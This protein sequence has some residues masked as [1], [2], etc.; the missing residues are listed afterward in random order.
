MHAPN[1]SIHKDARY[2]VP[3]MLGIRRLPN[4]RK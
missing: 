3:V 1:I 2:L 4:R